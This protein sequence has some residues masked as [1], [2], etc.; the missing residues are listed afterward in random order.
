MFLPKLMLKHD[1]YQHQLD[2]QLKKNAD[3]EKEK[4]IK[5]LEL[6][7]LLAKH[8]KELNSTEAVSNSIKNG[9]TNLKKSTK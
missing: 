8:R 3:L 7:D 6:K 5:K 1:L 2:L 9:K 4:T